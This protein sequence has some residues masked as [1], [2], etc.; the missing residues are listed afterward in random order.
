MAVVALE[1]SSY[2]FRV[3][4]GIQNNTFFHLI[5]WLLPLRTNP[6]TASSTWD[7]V[8]EEF[9]LNKSLLNCPFWKKKVISLSIVGSCYSI[10]PCTCGAPYVYFQFKNFRYR[11]TFFGIGTGQE[12]G[13]SN[14]LESLLSMPIKIGGLGIGN[15]KEEN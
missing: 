9:K 10:C 3:N 11:E 4:H 15:I 8:V 13:L 1:G 12:E 5:I 2:Y 14:K 7:L 6:T